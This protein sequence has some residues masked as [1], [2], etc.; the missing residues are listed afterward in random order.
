MKIKELLKR[1]LKHPELFTQG[2]LLYFR[3]VQRQRKLEKKQEE[4][5]KK[6][7]KAKANQTDY[8]R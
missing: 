3:R 5:A 1:A 2:E 6:E 4:A 8:L 7:A